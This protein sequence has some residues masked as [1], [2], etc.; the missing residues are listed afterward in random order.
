MPWR[1]RTQLGA[2]KMNE[3]LLWLSIWLDFVFKMGLLITV[4]KVCEVVITEFCAKAK[5]EK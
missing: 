3:N 2:P 1:G 4:Y 5:G